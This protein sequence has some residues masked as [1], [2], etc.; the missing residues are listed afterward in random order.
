M[1]DLNKTSL[2]PEARI[3]RAENLLTEIIYL[4]G[5]DI[6]VKESLVCNEIMRTPVQHKSKKTMINKR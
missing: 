3:I 5:R 1:S 2:V 4:N 6:K